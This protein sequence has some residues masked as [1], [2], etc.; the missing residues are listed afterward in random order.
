[1]SFPA[2][3]RSK[4]F[5]ETG[6]STHVLNFTNTRFPVLSLFNG[7]SIIRS[8]NPIRNALNASKICCFFIVASTRGMH[9]VKSVFACV[10]RFSVC[11]YIV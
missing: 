7:I 10:I 6:V 2:S 9:S 4:M 11:I 1:M 5:F 8:M 3:R